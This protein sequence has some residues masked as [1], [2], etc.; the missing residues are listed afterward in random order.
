MEKAIKLK[1][2]TMD[3]D[4]AI[5]EFVDKK[6]AEKKNEIL[7]GKE[8]QPQAY[9][10]IQHRAGLSQIELPHTYRFFEEGVDR[11]Q[12]RQYIQESWQTLKNHGPIASFRSQ[13]IAVI[14]ISD[15]FYTG[16]Y[17]IED[18]N[19]DEAI[20]RAERPSKSPNRKEAVGIMVHK[21]RGGVSELPLLLS[22]QINDFL[23]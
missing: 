21:L 20:A 15:M 4:K 3:A 13:L 22:Y 1:L 9:L 17:K 23:R 7:S 18:G 8:P 16:S 12:L 19:L 11:R 10:F 2:I 6:F 5:Q 14:L